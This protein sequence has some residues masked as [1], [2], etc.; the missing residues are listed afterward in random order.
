MLGVRMGGSWFLAASVLAL[1]GCAIEPAPGRAQA[2]II[3]GENDTADNGAV[4]VLIKKPNYSKPFEWCTGTT[5]SPHVV[6][7]AAHCLAVNLIDVPEGSTLSFFTGAY[8]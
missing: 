2:R 6:V 3:G 5:V 7:T 4:T 8:Y 1:A